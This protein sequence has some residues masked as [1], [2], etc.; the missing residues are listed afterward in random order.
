M[1]VILHDIY[2]G[3]HSDHT[4]NILVIIRGIYSGYHTEYAVVMIQEYTLVIL[5][6]VTE[7]WLI[8]VQF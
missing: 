3:H 6:G 8:V 5:Q 1:V 7:N 4:R 2:S